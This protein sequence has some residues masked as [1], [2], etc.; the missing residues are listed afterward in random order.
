MGHYQGFVLSPFLF[1]L[2]MDEL[3]RFIKEEVSWYM[4]FANDI[5]LIDETRG[6]VNYRLEVWR[7]T[8]E[9]K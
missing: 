3:T 2:V 7:H 4:L 1:A 8:L 5:V 6:K 9:S